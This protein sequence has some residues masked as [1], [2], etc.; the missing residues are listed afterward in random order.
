MAQPLQSV[1]RTKDKGYLFIGGD[2]LVVDFPFDRQQVDQIKKIQGA[3]WDK[4]GKV[5]RIPLASI[6][7]ARQFAEKNSFF[8]DNDV[9]RFDKP[10]TK[11]SR[12]TAISKEGDYLYLE[13]PYD[14]VKVHSVKQ[15][16]GITF[17]ADR[18]AW[19]APISAVKDVIKW[20]GAFGAEIPTD[21]T[22]LA[23]NI[24]NEMTKAIEMS[25]STR[26]SRKLEIPNL[27]GSLLDYQEAG[28]EYA[29]EHRR[30]FIA[31]EMGLGK[32][33]QAIATLEYVYDSY[34]AVVVCPPNLV[35]NWKAEYSKW[36][37][38]RKV[39]T[40]TNR[41]DFPTEKYDVL[42]IGYS[43]IPTWVNQLLKHRSYV[44]DESHYAKTP[45]A[46]RTKAAV[47]MARSCP[48]NGLVLCLTGTPITNRPAEYASQLDILGKLSFF[49]GLF[50]FY[51]RYCAAYK[52]RWGQWVLTGHSHLDELNEILRSSCYIRR[53]KDQVLSELPPVRHSTIKVKLDEKTM[54]EYAKAENE[55]VDY[56]V[57]QAVT[58]AK[59]IGKDPRSA[60][61]RAKIKASS[62]IHLSKLAVLRRL[63]AK[64]K[65]EIAGE[66]IA[67]QT[68]AGNK[69]VV[70]AHHR[71]VVDALASAHGGL[72]IQGGMEVEDVEEAKK[73][74]QSGDV[75]EAP[76]IILSIQAAKTGHTLTA[77]QDVLFV[78]LPW[79]PADV[80]QLYSRC[81]RIGQK[82]SVMVTYLI[83]EDTVDEQIEE[84]IKSK[85]RVVDNATEGALEDSEEFN[86]ATL[87][88]DLLMKGLE[89]SA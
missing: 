34:P 27:S 18:V 42:I 89:Q 20:A 47:K 63:V 44:F 38:K 59:E 55:F 3:K 31:D 66:L 74:F 11:S 4:V 19:R 83:A 37:P 78:E 29:A 58:I 50:G 2:H 8:I 52:D 17:D 39:V 10:K 53:T 49:G 46:K 77:A 24:E 7:E 51:R 1:M 23:N 28:V 43:N 5:W 36:L 76:A 85:R 57:Q 79:T 25:R 40:V 68:E 69:V 48:S 12:T 35:L 60:A 82:G 64:A 30:T 84:L 16:P 22:D 72:K 80:D 70:A 71:D 26:G 56:M 88:L 87:V 65:L 15:I 13:V 33:I 75:I 81:H 86:Q 67:A 6:E 73:K 62:S 14:R 61:V 21:I 54:K 32:T 9:L 41:S 45:T